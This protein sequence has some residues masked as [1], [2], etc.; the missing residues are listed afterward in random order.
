MIN[1]AAQ[2]TLAPATA[3][4]GFDRKLLKTASRAADKF[5]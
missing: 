2:F 1:V 4:Q 5:L 3:R